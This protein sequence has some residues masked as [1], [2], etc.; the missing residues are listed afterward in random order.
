M[1]IEYFHFSHALRK[2]LK[3]KKNIGGKVVVI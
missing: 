1:N 3:E 2:R